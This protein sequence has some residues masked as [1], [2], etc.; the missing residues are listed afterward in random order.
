LHD[1]LIFGGIERFNDASDT[2]GISEGIGDYLA[3]DYRRQLQPSDPYR[4]N[5]R[6]N[7]AE[8]PASL[9]GRDWICI[10]GYA[11]AK[12]P[13]P[14][15][16]NWSSDPYEKMCVWAS[17]LMDIEYTDA[18]NPVGHKR[19][20]ENSRDITVRLALTS[21]YYISA[22][23]TVQDYMWAIFQADMDIPE[24]KGMHLNDLADIF[25]N[26]GFFYYN[27]A[28]GNIT[29]NTT[30]SKP[31]L[32][33]GDITVNSGVTLAI[34]PYS[35]RLKQSFVF[36]EPTDDRASGIDASKCEIIVNGTF[37][38][39][40]TTFTGPSKGSWYGI[41][42]TSSGTNNS[43][44]NKCTIK[45][46]FNAVSIDSKSPQVMMSFI[47]DAAKYGVYITGSSAQP[48]IQHNYIEA[49]SA[50]V[51]H[52]NGGNGYFIRNSFRNARYGVWV[53]SGS[54]SYDYYATGRNIF[55][56]SI[57]QDKVKVNTGQ[58]FLGVS[59]YFTIPNSGYKY[60]RNFGAST[61]LATF[62]YWSANPPSATY[63]YGSVDRSNPLASPPTNPPAGPAWTLP[64]GMSDDFFAVFDKARMLFFDGKYQESREK[65]KELT[66]KYLDSE[67]SSYALNW[68]MLATEQLEGIETQAEYL[69]A[70]KKDKSASA[71]TRFY[72]LKWLLQGEMRT[73]TIEKAKKLAVE[74]EAGSI[75][76]REISF[77]LAMGLFE[78][79]GDRQ[80]AEEVLGKVSEKFAD[81]NTLEAVRCIRSQFVKDIQPNQP[82][83][84]KLEKADNGF[85]L[86]AFPNPSN[87]SVKILYGLEH[88]G[89]VSVA[90]YN[91]LGQKVL[92]LVDK[93]QEAGRHEAVWDGKDVNGKTVSSGMYLCRFETKGGYK[94]LKLLMT[95]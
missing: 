36:F 51:L 19:Y 62:D 74:A 23:A 91:I 35:S 81:D 95:K 16:G 60:I 41:L 86:G 54:P 1:A 52:F 58:P 7:W 93:E 21:L 61:I 85:T 72:A 87:A 47:D 83:L 78:Y 80:G 17:T 84:A 48:M 37:R 24:Y 57:Y 92:T 14:P 39:D 44:L 89:R 13:A 32:V 43:C 6:F 76:D 20:G 70:V 67:Y 56:T 88:S 31:M 49:D 79:K 94:T 46:A 28:S 65:F 40:S 71:N 3:I 2:R 30:W 73:G 90:I 29:T 26:R 66:G 18:T 77:D 8:P 50:C 53:I 64:K 12:Y 4:P 34:R 75:Y 45:N 9:G 22:S 5:H 68:Y 55:E 82:K 11:N 10:K 69:N 63:F 33:T 15:I 27:K 25:D 42:F 38:A 59:Q